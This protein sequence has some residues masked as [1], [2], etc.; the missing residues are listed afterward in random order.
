MMLRRLVVSGMVVLAVLVGTV[1]TQ[2]PAIGAGGLLYPYR[3][4]VLRS[5]PPTC[6]DTTYRGNGVSLKGWHCPTTSTKRGT[7]VYLH[8]V[9]DNRA[10]AAGVV[11][12][13]QRRG[14]DVVAYDSRA[15]GVSD[16]DICTY[17][18]FEKHDLSRVLD[19][20]GHEPI[21]LV[22]SS[23]G[24][25]VAL[26]AAAEDTRV[27]AVVAAEVFSDL[28][29]I[30]TERAPFFFTSGTIDEAIRLAELWGKFQVDAVSP[31]QAAAK[32]SIP[33]LLIH[34][35]ADVDTRPDH[36][37]R[38]FD[39]LSGQKRLIIVPAARHNQSLRDDVWNEIERWIDAALADS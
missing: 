3:S 30:A 13:F 18:F 1:A 19:T 33:V 5:P 6:N 35:A 28:R 20:I 2:L 10:S 31:Q 37:R 16:G 14:F 8:G 15:H 39:A 25:A 7:L 32:L 29:T 24:A 38:V 12:R 21:V 34:G 26:Q 36:S 11:H 9:A 23:L 4:P 27:K 17:G 22:G